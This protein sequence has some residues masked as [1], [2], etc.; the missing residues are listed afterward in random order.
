MDPCLSICNDMHDCR[1]QTIAAAF[2]ETPDECA[3][4]FEQLQT[5]AIEFCEKYPEECQQAFDTWL[6]ASDTEAEE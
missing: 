3:A 6:E 4:T 5:T 2:T 1:F